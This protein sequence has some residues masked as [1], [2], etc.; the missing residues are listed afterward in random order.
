MKAYRPKLHGPH[1]KLRG[2]YNRVIWSAKPKYMVHR[3]KLHGPHTKLHGPHREIVGIPQPNYMVHQ[4]TSCGPQHQAVRDTPGTSRDTPG[5]AQGQPR[6]SPG[7][8]QGQPRDS[9]R[10][11]QGQSNCDRDAANHTW[12][13][14]KFQ[15]RMYICRA[16]RT[17]RGA[18]K[19][20]TAGEAMVGNSVPWTCHKKPVTGRAIHFTRRPLRTKVLTA[21]EAM[22]GSVPRG[23]KVRPWKESY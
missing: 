5:T 22:G 16:C 18:N 11:A 23:K 9:P 3:P 4:A 14:Q 8:A 15:I 21:G 6:D 17:R 13:T 2:P 1:N 10:T 19:I 7:T 12:K 20:A